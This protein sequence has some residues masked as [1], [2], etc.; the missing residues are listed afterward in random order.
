MKKKTRSKT[1]NWSRNRIRNR[2]RNEIKVKESKYAMAMEYV[3]LCLLVLLGLFLVLELWRIDLFTYPLQMGKDAT[4]VLY[5]FN[6]T[7]ET[8]LVGYSTQTSYPY[9]AY[10][11]DFPTSG[12]ISKIMQLVFITIAGGNVVAALN[13][14]YIA[15]YLLA[16]ITAYWV[17]RR[18]GITKGIAGCT[19]ILYSFLPAHFMRSIGHLGHGMYWPI[20]IF[21]YF[22]INYLKGMD[23]W[24]KGE[25]GWVKKENIIHLF[26]LIFLGA[27][28]VYFTYFSCFFVCMIILYS[29]IRK[30]SRQKIKQM[31]IDLIVLVCSFLP[32]VIQYAVDVLRYG[33]NSGV[34]ERN[35]GDI[36]RYGL[37]IGQ[38]IMPISGHRISFLKELR[39]LYDKL[40]LSTENA[41]AS[42]G[43]LFSVGFVILLIELIKEKHEDE[44]RYACALMNLGCILLA[45]IGGLSSIIAIY[46]TQIR[47]YNR[48]SV[49]IAFC[50]AIAFAKYADSHLKK[51]KKLWGYWMFCAL[52]LGIGIYD[53]T[54][55][56][57][58]PNYESAA[59]EWDSDE[60]FVEQIEEMEESG[61]AIY[62]MPYTPY[63]EGG[64]YKMDSYDHAKGYIHSK[65]LMWSFG[66]YK[67]RDG[68]WWNEYLNTLSLDK[69]VQNIY[70]NDFDGI[71]VDSNAYKTEE[72]EKLYEELSNITGVKPIIS[73]NERLYYFTFKNYDTH[74]ITEN[75][76]V[77]ANTFFKYGE[78]FY[79]LERNEEDYWARSRNDSVIYIYNETEQ[80][81]DVQVYADITVACAKGKYTFTA[82]TEE[83][84][85]EFPVEAG[86]YT[87]INFPLML[88]P[89][90]NVIEFSTDAPAIK[91]DSSENM[92]SFYLMN[93]SY[94]CP[95]EIASKIT[96]SFDFGKGGDLSELNI[97]N[98]ILEPEGKFSWT[99]GDCMEM[100]CKFGEDKQIH[101]VI[102]TAAVAEQCQRV[103]IL[104]DDVEV[105]DKSVKEN[106]NIDF[107]FNSNS[108]GMTNIKVLLP[109]ATSPLELGLSKDDIELGLAIQRIS[110]SPVSF[111]DETMEMNQALSK[112]SYEF[113][114]NFYGLEQSLVDYWSW[115]SSNGSIYVYNESDQEV[116]LKASADI[117]TA[118]ENGEYELSIEVN[119]EMTDFSIKAGEYNRINFFLPLKPGKNVVELKSN[120]PEIQNE[121][122][123][124]T[125]A[126]YVKNFSYTG[127]RKLAEETADSISFGIDGDISDLNINEGIS[128]AEGQ[129]SWTLGNCL[130]MDCNFA[131]DKSIHGTIGIAEV[132]N[133]QQ[134]IRI[135][136]DGTEVF[137][138]IVKEGQNIEFDFVSGQDGLTNIQVLIPNA[139]SPQ[140]LQLGDDVRELG[141][142]IQSI[143]FSPN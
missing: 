20:P 62:Q 85:N 117:V 98:G 8:G 48:I 134:Q 59:E 113:G 72:F 66:C 58:I 34:M 74:E 71:Y 29:V 23:G 90:K 10:S 82:A 68:H 87:R 120:I 40:P 16:A 24:S 63:P 93:F 141:L 81:I 26:A 49:Y 61:A 115:C 114:E 5:V 45:T 127:S 86:K 78:E 27:Q 43:I 35:S 65:D 124:R 7:K 103:V 69:Q 116:I 128:V 22:C 97:M 91:I 36:E 122:D 53:Q 33:A 119:D 83:A 11:S 132:F 30:I 1:K 106:E 21:L 56:A 143:S 135:M 14:Y 104:V 129:Y 52:L 89:G 126:F 110:F 138:E 15:G 13:F 139:V 76:Y 100:N 54:S 70:L 118:Q 46:F 38:L 67:G 28:S 64:V 108:D 112:I 47:C 3:F 125:L 92:Y 44:E 136:V 31:F 102:K 77:M 39:A 37:K 2:A 80:Q 4:Q 95:R 131:E 137:D 50:S 25:R 133:H 73:E 107:Y 130:E 79:G 109:D 99:N 101:G 17:L 94:R 105:Y 19:A 84:V 123:K 6:Q 12:I 18:L 60:A 41:V 142:A 9:Y 88:K 75:D 42:L 57:Y 32:V 121:G 96:E 111:S 55:P 140:A 51:L